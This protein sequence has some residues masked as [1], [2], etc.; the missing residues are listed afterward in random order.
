MTQKMGIY[1]YPNKEIIVCG[2]F[3]DTSDIVEVEELLDRV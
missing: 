2:M 3:G 1:T